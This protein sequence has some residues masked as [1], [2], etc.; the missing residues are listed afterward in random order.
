MASPQK[1]N[2]HIDIANEIADRLATIRIPGREMQVLWVIFRKTW[3][4]HKKTDTISQSQFAKSTGIARRHIGRL[5]E[6]LLEKALIT[7]NGDSFICEYGIQKDW[8]QWK[9]SPKMV[10]VTKNGDSCKLSPN[11][12][13]NITKNGDE[14]VTKNGA[15][16]RKE[17]NNT[18]ETSQ[19]SPKKHLYKP[20]H[21]AL[22]HLLEK[23]IKEN[24]PD[25]IF[26][27]SHLDKWADDI[28]LMEERDKRKLPRIS[29]II[30][31]ALRNS[32]W[33][34]NIL[35]GSKLRIQ[36]DK[37]EMEYKEEKGG[38]QN[39]QH[40]RTDKSRKEDKY[41]DLYEV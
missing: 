38:N 11:L 13:S 14:T 35:S 10:I 18:K 31:W 6:G 27:G 8:E 21:L 1:E 41:K 37:L 28:R 29:E 32:F 26:A 39:R 23:L 36:F 17:R 33:K 24:K 7:K 20:E 30:G 34:K 22:A 2:G 40:Y 4:W 3:G 9:L 15:H 16:K 5:L 12:G 25:Y 19:V